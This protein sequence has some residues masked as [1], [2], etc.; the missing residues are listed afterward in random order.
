MM[1]AGN[2]TSKRMRYKAAR[3]CHDA[4]ILN[5]LGCNELCKGCSNYRDVVPKQKPQKLMGIRFQ[6]SYITPNGIPLLNEASVNETSA[7]SIHRKSDIVVVN[8]SEVCDDTSKRKRRK[9]NV[10]KPDA[11]KLS[12]ERKA[13]NMELKLTYYEKKIFNWKIY[14]AETRLK[15]NS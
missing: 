13:K 7:N 11:E 1:Q 3:T 8:E 10:K 5:E 9:Q 6:C 14:C 15:W 4:F 2:I 12:L